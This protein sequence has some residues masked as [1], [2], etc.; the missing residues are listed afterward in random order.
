MQLVVLDSSFLQSPDILGHLLLFEM[1]SCAL[2]L[3]AVRGVAASG[4]KGIELMSYFKNWGPDVEWWDND[5]PGNC[6]MG[7]FLAKPLLDQIEPYT[8]LNYGFSFLTQNPDPDQ[9]G[10]GTR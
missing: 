5:I 8:S 4:A 3:S 10:C 7:C 2:L 6:V 9:V 1:K